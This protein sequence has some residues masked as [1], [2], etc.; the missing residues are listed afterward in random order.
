MIKADLAAYQYKI[1]QWP[2]LWA[3]LELISLM[4]LKYF[5]KQLHV[6]KELTKWAKMLLK[7]GKT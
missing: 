2:G 5:N 3:N 6:L 4:R 7:F 1:H